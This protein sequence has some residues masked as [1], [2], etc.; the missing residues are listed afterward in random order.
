MK[1][2][3]L[4]TGVIILAV[5]SPYL[6][7]QEASRPMKERK[8]IQAA[9][10]TRA[11]KAEPVKRIEQLIDKLPEVLDLSEEQKGKLEE[12]WEKHKARVE[13]LLKQLNEEREQFQKELEGILTPE[14]KEKFTQ[15]QKRIKRAKEALSNR[16]KAPD[17]PGPALIAAAL[18]RIELSEEKKS[19]I[20]E[21]IEQTRSQIRD[22]REA[23]EDIRPIIKEFLGKVKAVLTEEE[24]QQLKQK[25][26]NICQ[27]RMERRENM[28]KMRGRMQ[29]MGP[30]MGPMMGPNK[31]PKGKQF[32]PDMPQRM[33]MRRMPAPP[34]ETQPLKD[35]ENKEEENEEDIW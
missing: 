14:Q 5:S 26:K 24:L 22:A 13:E 9:K 31:R 12:I 32:P 3:H 15:I 30:H 25:V 29:H 27:M 16:I 18:Q 6:L 1:V 2:K 10:A 8:A 19:K 35:D 21:I 34:A 11:R 17:L 4:I 28:D 7:A 23:G 33:R 20:E